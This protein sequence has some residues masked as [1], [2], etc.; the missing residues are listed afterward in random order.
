MGIT[1]SN[2]AP[3]SAAQA[4][5]STANRLTTMRSAELIWAGNARTANKPSAFYRFI[6]HSWQAAASLTAKKKITA[7]LHLICW[8]T[9]LAYS[10]SH[11]V[12]LGN[13]TQLYYSLE[14]YRQNYRETDR[15]LRNDGW[16]DSTYLSLARR[17]GNTTLFG[18]WQYN[19][20]VPE[21]KNIHNIENNAAYHRNGFNIGWI[22]QWQVLGGLNSRL[23]ASFANRRYKG[24]M[25]F[26]TEPQR[27]RERDL[28]LINLSHNKLSY[29]GITPTLNYSYSHTRS[30]APLCNA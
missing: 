29:K 8:L 12:N 16:H 7:A 13:A 26:G 15:A 24:I 6:R 30:N 20:F 23:T 18:G 19:R 10:F 11:M 1:L 27:N 22:Q 25:A 14:R 17:F 28:S 5:F 2:S 4:I 21:N 3:T 9:E